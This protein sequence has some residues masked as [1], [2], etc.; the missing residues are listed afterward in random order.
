MRYI[1]SKD[2][3]YKLRRARV[4]NWAI[5]EV[6]DHKLALIREICENYDIDGFELDFMRYPKYFDSAM[7]VESRV[8][9]ITDFVT[10][11]RRILDA[12]QRSGK[13]RWLC[14]RV[15]SRLS[16]HESIGVDLRKLANIGVDMVNLS[17]HFICE[18]QSDLEKVHQMLPEKAIYLEMTF[19]N[20]RYELDSKIDVFRKMTPEQFYTG[21]HLAY[22]RGASGVSLYNFVYYRSLSSTP[23][24][25]PFQILKNLNKP[26][27]LA[28]QPQHYFLT[29]GSK[30]PPVSE[31]VFPAGDLKAGGSF[32]FT[33]DMAPPEK[34]WKDHSTL[35]IQ[36]TGPVIDQKLSIFF[37]GQRLEKSDDVS[38]PFPT[39]DK[40]GL[41]D[42]KKLRAWKV[43]AKLFVN[44]HNHLKVEHIQGDPIQ[45][46]FVDISIK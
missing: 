30:M 24:E 15:P 4:L 10:R 41:G 28:F 26:D 12:S 44:G 29:P 32:T 40:D 36:T 46:Q 20:L 18:Q 39:P 34:G 42:S 23:T 43:P 33:I 27:W 38:A 35:R 6:R 9:I 11:V 5:P 21:A 2:R 3:R 1:L 17:S 25:P 31:R 45:M 22:E 14:I 37:N 13:K 16:Q 7:P 8:E 19:S